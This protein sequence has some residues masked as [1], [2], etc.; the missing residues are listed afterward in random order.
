[1]IRVV[2]GAGGGGSAPAEAPSA[3]SVLVDA[4]EDAAGRLDRWEA[5]V[6]EF[7]SVGLTPMLDTAAGDAVTAEAIA[8]FI[9]R[10][11]YGLSCMR[12][13]IGSLAAGLQ[14]AA[15][16]YRKVEASITAAEGG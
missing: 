6:R 10:W 11:C 12:A 3:V 1:M 7:P 9:G 2:A 16:A 14:G 13:D 4:L 8:S 5:M 15:A